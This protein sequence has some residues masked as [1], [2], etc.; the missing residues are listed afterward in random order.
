M[1]LPPAPVSVYAAGSLREALTTLARDHEART[2]QQIALTFGASGL[3]RERIERGEGAQLFASA[4]TGHPQ[5]LADAG[6]WQAP[7]VFARNQLCALTSD[8]IRTTPDTLLA[9]LLDPE[10]RVGTS[11]PEA[12][13]SG[14]YA[15]ALFRRADAVQRGAYATLD[16]KALKLTGNPAA[17]LAPPGRGTYAWLMDEGLAD[18]F[19]TYRTNAIVAQQEVPR[20]RVVPLPDDLQVGAAYGLGVRR[21]AP[22]AALRF[23]HS[24][25][26]PAA[27]QLLRSLGFGAPQA[28]DAAS[29]R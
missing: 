11:T 10:V 1:P 21:D 6:G 12:D 25:G 19:L 9:T 23:A 17:P 7:L 22:A 14:D 2:G 16:A 4:D 29:L 3:L 26:E 13:P 27:Q 24:L 28:D 20:L 8:R 18:V 5:R 15:W